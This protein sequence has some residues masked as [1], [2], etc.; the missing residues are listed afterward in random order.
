MPTTRELSYALYGAWLLARR[1]PTG[2]MFFDSSVEGCR[3]SFAAGVLIYP[4]YLI[5]LGLDLP[6]A[7]WRD[8]GAFQLLIV[9]TIAYVTAWAALP[10]AFFAL[11]R[12]LGR[13]ER[14]LA[15]VTAYNWSQ[16]LQYTVLLAV[17]GL[18]TSGLLPGALGALIVDVGVLLLYVYCWYIARVSLQIGGLQ[19]VAFVLVDI[20][21]SRAILNVA[22]AI[23]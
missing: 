2:L 10:L 12:L 17:L 8:S 18:K 13:E 6:D 9:Q 5:L 21:L 11:C 19:A 1:N 7:T 23:G 20:V 15:Y 22:D 4:A 16:I 14:F 3:R